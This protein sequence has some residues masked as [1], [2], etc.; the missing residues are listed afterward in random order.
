MEAVRPGGEDGA[1]PAARPAPGS[2]VTAGWCRRRAFGEHRGVL[3]ALDV[4]AGIG[5][6]IG[7]VAVHEHG[8]RL[9][10]RLLGVPADEVRVDLQARPPVTRLRR[11][12]SWLGPDDPGCAEAFQ[13]HVASASGAWWFVAGGFVLE[14]VVAAVGVLVLLAVGLAPVATV[15][16]GHHAAPA[17]GL[18]GRGPAGD[19]PVRQT[20]R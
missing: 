7:L 19:G 3:W 4:L 11:E 12:G 5:F 6:A 15:L 14:G 9:T 10:A 2:V 18:P 13:R 8:H 1:E 16:A 20:G 17:R